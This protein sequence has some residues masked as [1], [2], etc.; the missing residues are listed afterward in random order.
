MLRALSIYIEKGAGKAENEV[1]KAVARLISVVSE[2]DKPKNWALHRKWKSVKAKS[3][4][5]IAED[6]PKC[7]KHQIKH[8]LCGQVMSGPS[9]L[10]VCTYWEK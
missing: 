7:K 1:A 8:K 2:S 5:V 9:F 10:S 6:V 3:T 4:L